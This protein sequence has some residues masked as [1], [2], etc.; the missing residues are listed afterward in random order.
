MDA[1]DIM[2]K[3]IVTIS[4]EKSA[5]DAARLMKKHDIGALPIVEDNELIG[6]ITESDIF[7][8]VSARNIKP[9][10]VTVK[11]IMTEKVITAPPDIKIHEINGL[12]Y[13]NNIRRILI[14]NDKRKVIGIVSASDLIRQAYHF[15]K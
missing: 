7:K 12:L 14:V 3:K 4:K 8:E 6:I 11:S 15:G 9:D 10:T 13:T 5:Y 1:N 2:S